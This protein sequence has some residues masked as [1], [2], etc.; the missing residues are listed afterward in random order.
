MFIHAGMTVKARPT[1]CLTTGKL[2]GELRSWSEW[3][4]TRGRSNHGEKR[5]LLLSLY[6]KSLAQ[7]KLLPSIMTSGFNYKKNV[8]R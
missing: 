4:V 7:Y 3:S 1:G 5:P 8:T 2:L 6:I